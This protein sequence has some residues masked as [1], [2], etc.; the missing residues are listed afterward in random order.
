MRSVPV[1][2]LERPTHHVQYRTNMVDRFGTRQAYIGA[3]AWVWHDSN[4]SLSELN[5]RSHLSAFRKK[6]LE[7][8]GTDGDMSDEKYSGSRKEGDTSD[9]VIEDIMGDLAEMIDLSGDEVDVKPPMST[10]HD[11]PPSIDF[12]C[13]DYVSQLYNGNRR[14]GNHFV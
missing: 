5:G 12:R 10:A 2:W 14:S 4:S 13:A 3:L 11:E 9:E 6:V 1:G 7:D 8:D